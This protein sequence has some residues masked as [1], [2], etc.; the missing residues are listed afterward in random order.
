MAR[1]ARAYREVLSLFLALRSPTFYLVQNQAAL[2]LQTDRYLR[3]LCDGG[4]ISRP[5]RDLALRDAPLLRPQPP[6]TRPSTGMVNFVGQ[7]A[8][9][10]VRA[11]LLFL[12][13]VASLYDLDRL[14]L[15][16]RTTYD[17]AAQ[18]KITEFLQGLSDPV[19]MQKAGLR[20]YQ[21]LDQGDPAAVIYS[22]TL[23]ERGAGANLLRVQSDNYNQPLD[24][25]QGTKL[26]LGSTAKLR[27][28]INYLEIVSTLHQQ[29]AAISPEELASIAIIPGD[30]LTQWAISYLSTATDKRL[31]PMLE[32]ALQ[33]KYSG[34]PGEAFFTA[35]GRHVFA[36]FERSENGQIFTV[37]QAFQNSVNLVFIRLLR[38]IERYYMYR[39]PG[40]SPAVSDRSERSGPA[41][42]S[43]AVR[44]FRRTRVPST[45][46]WQISRPDLRTRLS[47]P[48]RRR[49]AR[50]SV[51]R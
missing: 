25:N 43:N 33:R 48:W 28:L 46:L 42:I 45:L 51:W 36:N 38:D 37:S 3:A 20:G 13:G 7:K 14:D 29:Y 41:R 4:I 50:R 18:S 40:A 39:V 30:A 16:V 11:S 15:T 6:E 27:T 26:Q 35:G 10:A 23:F 44:R 8:P 9:D 34:G 17:S 24:I 2:T 47:R 12:T 49:P 31:Q 32:A 19:R 1:R 21:L 5:L 22:V